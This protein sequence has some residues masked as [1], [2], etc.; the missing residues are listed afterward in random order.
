MQM[1]Y[2]YIPSEMTVVSLMALESRVLYIGLSI[3]RGGFSDFIK[4]EFIFVAEHF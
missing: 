4:F 3:F 1:R 2:G